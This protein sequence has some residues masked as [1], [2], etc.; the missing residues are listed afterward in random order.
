MAGLYIHIP[1]CRRKCLYCDFYSAGS[2]IADWDLFTQTLLAELNTRKLEIPPHLSTLYIGGGTPSLIPE[3]NFLELMDGLLSI[4]P[5]FSPKEFTLEANPE[6]ICDQNLKLWKESGVNRLS[7]GVQSLDNK[8]LQLIGRR[9]TGL[10]AEKAIEKASEYF[11]HL[12]VDVMFGLPQQTLASYLNT[13]QKIQNLSPAHISSYSLMLEEGTAMTHLMREKKLMQPSENE[14]MDLY[15]L[16]IDFLENNGY[17]RYEISNFAKPGQESRHNLSYWRGEGYLGLG[18]GAH[19]YDG[20]YIRRA[21]PCDIKGYLRH[22]KVPSKKE[23]TTPFY[24]EEILG[25]NELYEELIMTRLRTA[26]GLS[27]DEL[28]NKFG[29]SVKE[30]LLQKSSGFIADGILQKIDDSI[31]FTRKGFAISDFVFSMLI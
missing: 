11:D 29:K 30:N 2:R 16:T 25:P 19:S 23:H 20:K 5:N 6:D 27:L 12:S 1:F 8:E 14:W 26:E 15:D 24:T 10:E 3:K 21:N 22:F 17:I 28:E 9:H 13:L 31:K 4:L 18:P 7:I